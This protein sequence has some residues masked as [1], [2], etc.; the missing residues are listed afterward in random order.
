MRHLVAPTFASAC[1]R[2]RDDSRIEYGAGRPPEASLQ[3]FYQRRIDPDTMFMHRGLRFLHEPANL[4]EMTMLNPACPTTHVATRL[5]LVATA[6]AIASRN[7]IATILN[8]SDVLL[9]LD[10]PTKKRALEEISRFL[11]ARHGLVDGEVYASLVEREEIGSTALGQGLAIPHARV[12]GLS[13]AIAAFVRTEIP[14]P[15]DAPDGKP[16]GDMLVILV[17]QAATDAHLLL[18]AQAA[19]MFCDLSFRER[20][21]ASVDAADV[22]ATFAQWRPS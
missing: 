6:P 19:E 14:I 15:F 22:H 7:A 20:L 17:P 16:V 12:P 5:R 4:R 3:L 11:G 10:V 13:Q 8:P 1:R 2:S 21:R 18:L 9:D